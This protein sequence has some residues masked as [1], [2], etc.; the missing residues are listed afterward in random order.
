ML[1]FIKT[2]YSL[3]KSLVKIDSLID[4]L[5]KDINSPSIIIEENLFS[6][7]EY[8]N[9]T[10]KNNLKTIYG[11]EININE[12]ILYLLIVNDIGYKN[13]IN[14][15]ILRQKN[16]LNIKDLDLYKEGLVA[17]VPYKSLVIYNNIK[18]IFETF[19]CYQNEEEKINEMLLTNNLIEYHQVLSLN[20]KDNSYLKY[21]YKLNNQEIDY[22][23]KEYL[24]NNKLSQVEK[25]LIDKI[26][27]NIIFPKMNIPV[28]KNPLN[29]SKE[30]LK[31]LTYNGLKKR[32]NN[33][34]SEKYLNR[35]NYELSVINKMGFVD[36]F[37]I[38]YDYVLFAKKNNILV[39]PGRGSAAGSLVSYTLGITDVDP[40]KYNLFFER[41][42]N[43]GRVSLPD[44]DVD[45]EAKRRD[46]VVEYLKEKY[47]FLHV[48]L[49]QTS[50]IF[51][52]KGIIRELGKLLNIE[53]STINNLCK[54]LNNSKISD[55]IKNYKNNE[56]LFKF[57]V[58]CD[59]LQGLK[60]YYSSHAAGV[61]T[62]SN[63]VSDNIPLFINDD[64]ILAGTSMEYLESTGLVKMDILSLITL[65]T[66][67]DVS[68]SIKDLD[69]NN[70]PLDDE[71][72]FDLFKNGNTE[73]IF[74]FESKGMINF[75][76]KFK[77]NSFNDIVCAISFYRPGPL[78][79]ID[80]LLK[81]KNTSNIKYLHPDL[82]PILSDTYG[83]IAYQEQILQ[84]LYKIGGY[85]L[86]EADLIRKSISKKKEDILIV[87][88][89]NFIEKAIVNGY[90]KDLAQKI[91]D[92]I[93]KFAGYGFNKAHAVSYALISYKIAYIKA[94]YPD[95]FNCTLLNISKKIDIN[96][97]RS[98]YQLLKPSINYSTNDYI[99]KNNKLLFPL[100]SIKKINSNIIEKILLERNNGL[101]ID[102]FN[103]VS[104]NANILNKEILSN[105]IY[106]GCFNENMSTL[107]KNIDI[108]LNYKDL[109]ADIDEKLLSK[110]YLEECEIYS[111]VDMMN[112]EKEVFGFF[113][114]SHPAAKYNNYKFKNI[115]DYFDKF[116]EIVG[117][118]DKINEINTKKND[119][120][121][122]IKITD[123]ISQK[124]LVVFPK[125]IK[126]L[127]NLHPNDL[128]KA[129]G[130]VTK[131]F[132]NYQI[133]I[134]KIECI[135]EAVK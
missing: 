64:N 85:T 24:F 62:T 94:N 124:E 34:V 93:I 41:F 79:N 135:N 22:N 30:Y 105:L 112:I 107:I 35:L 55:L 98:S 109:S 130:K 7:I 122:F 54:E 46:E 91:F 26:N 21:L 83:I 5:K 129:Y 39:G 78:E 37:L 23:N 14:I 101:Y 102:I 25:R 103:F 44:I 60:K 40:L 8:Y 13:I 119:K 15:D 108:I 12:N 48:C 32:L 88:K 16:E 4:N 68:S 6:L 117:I 120:M 11:L 3:Y 29:N 128:I 27:L 18:N 89:N 36:Y 82:I 97:L 66:L 123:E 84:I 67:K 74:Q 99:I 75:L 121:A 104:R 47:G 80:E 90:E 100:K 58:V 73:N 45:F 20:K 57:L 65:N 50:N 69:I 76:K 28:Y 42:L 51:G 53:D 49:I 81:N 56:E 72:T 106:G 1:N 9:K 96:Y 38:V 31:L 132:D 17:L 114:S 43:I 118:I 133:N 131:R 110:P 77:P 111:S 61:V 116:I 92:Q 95:E 70:I 52:D 71:K 113:L 125:S 134:T 87:E 86:K 59:K 2:D 127:D 115:S 33:N 63:L 10:K 126:Y 19:L